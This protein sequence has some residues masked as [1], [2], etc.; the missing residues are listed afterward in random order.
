LCNSDTVCRLGQ[1]CRESGLEELTDEVAGSLAFFARERIT[2]FVREQGGW[3]S[4]GNTA[5]C[6]TLCTTLCTI[7]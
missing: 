5:L 7:L 6:T 3:V 4:Q 1:H 2:P